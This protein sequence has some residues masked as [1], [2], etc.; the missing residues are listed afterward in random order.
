MGN[1][2]SI[3]LTC[4]VDYGIASVLSMFW[5]HIFTPYDASSSK[6][7]TVIEGLLQ[8]A[9]LNSSLYWGISAFSFD[10]MDNTL[11]MIPLVFF[12][13]T[14]SPNMIMKLSASHN[15][16]RALLGFNFPNLLFSG[17]FESGSGS[18]EPKLEPPI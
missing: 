4:A 6:T 1:F 9:A 18:I 5:E 11:G 14:F 3:A 8:F 16:L 7:R 10:G 12:A 13:Y 2:V 17:G 15:T